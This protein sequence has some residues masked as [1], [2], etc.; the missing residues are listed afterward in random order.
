MAYKVVVGKS[1][2]TDIKNV[3]D[4]YAGESPV[5]LEK[6]V[7]GFYRCLDD[8]SERP[9]SF[10]LVRQRTRFRRVKIKR[11]P[12]LIVFRVDEMR[13]RVF[14]AALIH[15]KRNPDIWVKRLR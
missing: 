11:F 2:H 15:E 5:A 7:Q 1:A 8:L 4:W 3:L 14:I 9:E 6:F 13:S 10:G 12:Y